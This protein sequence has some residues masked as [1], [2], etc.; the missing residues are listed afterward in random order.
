MFVGGH[1]ILT[2]GGVM[3]KSGILM[4]A[5]AAQHHSVPFVFLV[6]THKL[7]PIFPQDP[8]LLLNE[9]RSPHEII[10]YGE[11]AHLSDGGGWV[12]L[13]FDR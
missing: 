12:G 8:F 1:E 13:P 3:A 9:F 7:S 2:D 11:L 5:A 10:P 6:G 4:V